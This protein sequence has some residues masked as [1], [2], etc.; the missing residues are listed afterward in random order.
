ME[1]ATDAKRYSIESATR[2]ST[3]A[4]GGD[5]QNRRAERIESIVYDAVNQTARIELSDALR[6]GYVYDIGIDSLCE[7]AQAMFFPA[8]AFYTMRKVPK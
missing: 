8:Q 4:Y 2:T 5:D 1:H 6:E 7:E 3:P